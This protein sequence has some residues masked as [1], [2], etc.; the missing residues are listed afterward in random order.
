MSRCTPVRQSAAVRGLFRGREAKLRTRLSCPPFEICPLTLRQWVHL[1][2]RQAT[3]SAGYRNFSIVFRAISIACDASSD[4]SHG[5]LA[6]WPRSRRRDATN[7]GVQARRCRCSSGGW[8]PGRPTDRVS[9]RFRRPAGQVRAC[10][11]RTQGFCDAAQSL[12]RRLTRSSRAHRAYVPS[13]CA[14]TRQLAWLW[15]P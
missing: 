13:R 6:S 1:P 7:R 12:V 11:P 2:D 8:L 4:V 5:D 10:A 15:R 3:P 14:Q 9:R